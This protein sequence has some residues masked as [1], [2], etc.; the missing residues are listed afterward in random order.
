MARH[1][2]PVYLHPAR[3]RKFIKICGDKLNFKDI[4]FPVRV[5]DIHKIDK[6]NSVSINVFRYENKKKYP[7]YTSKWCCE[8]K[9]VDLKI[10][11]HSCMITVE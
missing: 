10:L 3:I 8:D 4:K 9:H 7:V 2:H 6:K 5:G 1:L 11:T